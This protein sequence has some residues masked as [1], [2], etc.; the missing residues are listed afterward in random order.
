[1]ARQLRLEF[2]GALY[3]ITSRGNRREP[4]FEDDVDHLVFL[5][6]LG[7]VC[8]RLNWQC[9][10]YCLMT[11]H[12]HLVIETA[13]ANLSTG[14]RQLNGVYTQKYNRRHHRVGHLMQGR[15]KAIL[16]D[17]DSYMME[18]ARY[19][20]LNPVRAHMVVHPGQ[21]NWSS[22]GAMIRRAHPPQWLARDALLALFGGTR[23]GASKKYVQFVNAGDAK[24]A[25]WCNLRHR[26]FLGDEAFV[27]QSLS[28]CGNLD[29]LKEIPRLER[30]I[31]A[32]SL[33]YY[34]SIHPDRDAAIC[35]A[36]ETGQYS[37]SEIAKYIGVHYSTVSRIVKRSSP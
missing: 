37:L 2:S 1:M 15:Y 22:Y 34:F 8:A 23:K 26:M 4:I 18:L 14:M 28:Q 25:I 33:D 6:L 10:A 27:E 35:A 13:E 3:H 11:N 36:F 30:R 9:Y 5:E 12:Y 31:P 20:V 19:V 32:R 7:Q 21:W 16:V 29:D 17:K 24:S